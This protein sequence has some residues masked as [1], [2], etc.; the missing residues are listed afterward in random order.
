MCGS[1]LAP[2]PV[3]RY[4]CRLPMSDLQTR[5][6][7][8]LA[9]RY[10][11]ER[12]VGRGGMATV[13]LAQDLRHHR[14]VALKVLHPELAVSLG[15]ERFLRE[16]QIAARLQHPHI[17][18]LL[19][20]GVKDGLLYYTMPRVE[21]ETLRARLARSGELPAGEALRI[22]RAVLPGPVRLR[23][24]APSTPATRRF[25]PK[26]NIPIVHRVKN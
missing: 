19:S 16:I 26:R 18:P 3:L 21:G 25:V 24:P 10:T 9:E 11:I 7:T 22:L 13:F 8:I 5:L 1:A 6:R 23:S 17:V 14:P 4:L 2:R 15:S 12:E 20:A